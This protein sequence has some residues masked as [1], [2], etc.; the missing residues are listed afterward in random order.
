MLWGAVG[1][2]GTYLW[3]LP[4]GSRREDDLVVD[5]GADVVDG[6]GGAV[7]VVGLI[8]VLDVARPHE[9]GEREGGVELLDLED[10]GVLLRRRRRL[11]VCGLRGRRRRIAANY[12]LT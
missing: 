6:G 7:H 2:T 3:V 9:R 5:L 1:A 10:G 8:R 11:L 4:N 12:N